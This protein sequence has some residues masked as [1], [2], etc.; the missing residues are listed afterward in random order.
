MAAVFALFVVIGA[1][2]CAPLLPYLT[3]GLPYTHFPQPGYEVVERFPAD[4]LQFYYHL[5]LLQ[6]GL[7]GPTP[8]LR[9]PYEFAWDGPQPGWKT[10][11]VPTSLLFVAL[12]PFGTYV[13]YN[14]FVLLSFG[15]SGLAMLLLAREVAG[16]GLPAVLAGVVFALAP[17]RYAVLLGGHPAGSS[18]YLVPLVFLGIELTIRTGSRAWSLTAGA[19]TVSV[20]LV[21]PHY[22]YFLGLV[23]PAFVFVRMLPPLPDLGLPPATLAE[24][25]PRQALRRGAPALAVL[26]AA[27]L[28]PLSGRGLRG[29][30]WVIPVWAVAFTLLG[31]LWIAS[32]LLLAGLR[33]APLGDSLR[34]GLLC[35]VPLGLLVLS[36][37]R[38]RWDLPKLTTGLV[39][40]AIGLVVLGHV[41]VL[42]RHPR[43]R[44]RLASAGRAL[45]PFWPF[46]LLGLAA[47]AVMLWLRHTALDSVAQTGR[48]LREIALYSPSAW[49]WL[50]RFNES[51]G[52]SIYPGV[53]AVGLLLIGLVGRTWSRGHAA[54]RWVGFLVVLFVLAEILTLGANAAPLPLYQ[55]LYNLVPFWSFVRQTSKFQV[56]AFL[57]LALLA[58]IGL[59]ALTAPPGPRR[60][61]RLGL[62]VGVIV[63]V[64]ADYWPARP[65]GV[66]L[67]PTQNPVYDAL[68]QADGGRVLYVP[69]WP[70]DSSW[71]SV[72]EFMATLTRRPMINGYSPVVSRRYV[73]EVYWPLDHVNRGELTAREYERLRA[74]GV[75]YLVVDRGAFPPKV[76]PF[77]IGFTLN[78]LRA[79]P[80]VD[81]LIEA[82]PVWLFAL[83]ETPR[84]S[85]DGLPTTP[86]GIFFEA[87]RLP[88]RVG[89]LVDEPLASWGRAVGVV[90][91]AGSDRRGYLVLGAKAG[92]PRGAFRMIFRLRGRGP[93]D[94]LVA[95]I[96]AVADHGGRVLASRPLAG[97]DLSGQ[98]EDHAISFA[99]D[100]PEWVEFRVYWDGRGDLA[101]DYLYGLFADQSDPP[102][103]FRNDDFAFGH[104]PY[105]RFPPGEYLLRFRTRV[106]Q[107]VDAPIVRFSVVTAHERAPL[108]TRVVRG[109]DLEVAGVYQE[110]TL[111]IRVDQLR[112]LEILIDFLTTGLS[113]DQITVVSRG[114]S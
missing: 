70:G 65:V 21:E 80:Y 112:V 30:L 12:S 16:P 103:V 49:D 50:V 69:I 74:L 15:L 19:A 6:D 17:Y 95:R 22:L 82:S 9:D 72:Y 90:D 96:E 18:F 83:R 24:A 98:Y 61:A 38:L 91:P 68:R 105:R 52:R 41:W 47:A 109:T 77:N 45:R 36:P 34:T 108:A 113:V 57:A 60:R 13:A 4:Y 107:R 23:L 66:S 73:D 53:V 11:F 33:D 62:A 101:V 71:S 31:V 5:W 104:G 67:L 99:L 92:F 86:Y 54:R 35:L 46:V 79:S 42:W 25:A 88:R 20:A 28:A 55:W 39:L 110:I 14:G 64:V 94:G 93:A 78:R 10:Y 43:G 87:E 44:E 8:L 81:L 63:L 85:P 89:R 58:A 59:R 75:R 40:L 1:V 97:R 56:L 26:A 27:T 111:P 84:P 7:F 32:G 29:W 48:S 37:A 114:E 51:A 3:R 102:R 76:S 100:R 2:Y 106:D